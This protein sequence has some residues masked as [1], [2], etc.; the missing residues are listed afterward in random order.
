MRDKIL[1]ALKENDIGKYFINETKKSSAELFFV[2]KKLDLSRAVNVTDYTVTV[3]KDFESSGKMLTGSSEFKIEEGMDYAEIC[4]KVKAAYEACEY[5]G[6]P[7]FSFE[8]GIKEVRGPVDDEISSLSLNDAA[9]KIAEAVFR[10]DNNEEAFVNSAEIFIY[11]KQVRI[12]GGNGCDVSY[13]TYSAE[14]EFVVQ[15]TKENDVEMYHSFRYDSL[16]TEALAEKV[17][18]ALERVVLRSEAKTAAPAGNYRVVLSDKSVET[19]MSY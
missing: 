14:G 1:L 7:F 12:T 4:D 10:N 3:Y 16:D 5:A 19:I 15:C 8:P 18:Q 17:K 11:K 9:L 2:K 13:V 6:N